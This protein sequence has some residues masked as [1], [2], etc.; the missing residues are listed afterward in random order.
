MNRKE[1]I[2]R[3]KAGDKPIDISI[4]KWVD[5]LEGSGYDLSGSNC[6][7]CN[8][9]GWCGKCPINDYEMDKKRTGCAG[10]YDALRVFTY[11]DKQCMLSLLYVI[12]EQTIKDGV[13]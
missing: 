1:M 11:E 9:F 12:K 3:I 4:D 8:V 2:R 10:I 13:Y 6:A 7:C 5:I